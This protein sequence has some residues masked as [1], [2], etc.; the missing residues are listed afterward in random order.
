MPFVHAFFSTALLTFATSTPI[1]ME[2]L[3]RLR[4]AAQA[5]HS[6]TLYVAQGETV[7]G[8]WQFDGPARPLDIQSIT[9]SVGALV[10]GTVIGHPNMPS[11]QTPVAHYFP[12]WRQGRKAQVTLA[13]VLG[14]TT[15]IQED[16]VNARYDAHFADYTQ[17]A[18]AAEL[19]CRPGSVVQPSHKAVQLLSGVVEAACNVPLDALAEQN[20]FGPLGITDYAWKYD[21][22]GHPDMAQGLMMLP[23]DL[24][25]VG[26]L[27]LARGAHRGQRIVPSPYIDALGGA[28]EGTTFAMGMLWHRMYVADPN[29]AQR[30]AQALV[31]YGLM[32]QWLVLIPE[33]DV[34]VVRQ[35][36]VAKRGLKPADHAFNQL[37]TM[38]LALI[39][40]EIP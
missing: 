11:L 17:F 24:A 7:L 4:D 13:H 6:S 12:Q 15:C 14:N 5:T 31:A 37:A 23:Q 39:E 32:G 18:L 40:P 36:D 16:D 9:K 29:N 34:I 26:R 3:A 8:H 28:D 2:A 22:A 38:A 25:A 33:A 20:L 19:T 35:Y 1:N 10:L 27:V 21:A 30:R